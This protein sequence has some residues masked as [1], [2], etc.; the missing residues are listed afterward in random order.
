MPCSAVFV[1]GS[2]SSTVVEEILVCSAKG[3]AEPDELPCTKRLEHDAFLSY[4]QMIFGPDEISRLA[5]T[6]MLV[7]H[8][9]FAHN[10][11]MQCIARWLSVTGV[12]AL[13]ICDP[14]PEVTHHRRPGGQRHRL[15]FF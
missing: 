8:R 11:R 13:L 10:D 3:L 4:Q 9:G 5:V 15:K 2:F 12:R 1:T 7:G 6:K 14:T